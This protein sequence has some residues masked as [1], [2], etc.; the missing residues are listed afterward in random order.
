MFRRGDRALAS[1]KRNQ[2]LAPP[3][4]LLT[5]ARSQP[6]IRNPLDEVYTVKQ[7]QKL[8]GVFQWPTQGGRGIRGCGVERAGARWRLRSPGLSP[9]R[10]EHLGL[11]GKIDFHRRAD[12][13]CPAESKPDQSCILGWHSLRDDPVRADRSVHVRPWLRFLN[14][15]AT[16]SNSSKCFRNLREDVQIQSWN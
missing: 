6:G 8:C 14:A 12:P 10:P 2:L 3:L 4:L 15:I 5:Y 13:P 9:R 1:V 11:T 7:K 16:S